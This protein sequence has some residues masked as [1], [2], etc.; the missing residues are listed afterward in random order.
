MR[1]EDF[2]FPPVHEYE[3]ILHKAVMDKRIP[4]DGPLVLDAHLRPVRC[5]WCRRPLAHAA[6][7]YTCLHCDGHCKD[8]GACPDCR[9][10]RL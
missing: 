1:E 3:R 7:G 5:R 2:V 10:A 6:K 8:P 9:T 4:I